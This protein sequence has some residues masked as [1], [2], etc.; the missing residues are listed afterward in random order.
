[1]HPNIEPFIKALNELD[2][3]TCVS[4]VDTWMKEGTSVTT[5]Y[6][7]V[8]VKALSLLSDVEEDPTHKIWFEHTQSS[9][10][11][12]LIEMVHPYVLSQRKSTLNLKAAVICPDQEQHELGAR[13]INDYLVLS[14]M[15]SYFVGRDTPRK[16]FVDMIQ[17]LGLDVVAISVTNYYHLSEVKKTIDLINANVND[18]TLLLGGRAILNNPGHFKDIPNVIELNSSQALFHWIEGQTV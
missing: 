11:R 5:L 13:M 8:F 1:M 14:G 9:I 16:E 6:E 7:D 15:K 4:I 10:I 3:E 17:T 12:T 2:K 18:V